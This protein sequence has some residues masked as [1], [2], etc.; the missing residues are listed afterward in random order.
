MTA[1]PTEVLTMT[2]SL[3]DI[4]VLNRLREFFAAGYFEEPDQSPMRRWS[5][6]V[7][8]RFEH[9]SLPAYDG[10]LLYPCGPGRVGSEDRILASS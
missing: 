9:R 2:N 8:R 1:K 6:A 5:R 7:Q 4:G 3:P 10:Q